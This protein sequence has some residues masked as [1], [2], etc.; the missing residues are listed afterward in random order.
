MPTLEQIIV[1]LVIG[2]LA[3]SAA[4]SLVRRHLTLGQMIV[5]GLLGAVVGGILLN[6]LDINAPDIEL[7]FSTRDLIAALVGSGLLIVFAELFFAIKRA[8][9]R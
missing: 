8:R 3:G 9:E 6:V 4:G 5:T 2:V 7:T 1:W